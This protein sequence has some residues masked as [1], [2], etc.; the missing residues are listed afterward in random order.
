MKPLFID[1]PVSSLRVKDGSLLVMGKEGEQIQKF[2]PK[3]NSM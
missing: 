3:Y 2:N 1:G